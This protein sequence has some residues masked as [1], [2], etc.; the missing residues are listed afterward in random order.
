[1]KQKKILLTCFEPFD[2]RDRNA[3]QDVVMEMPAYI[4]EYRIYKLCLPTVFGRAADLAIEEAG[5]IH[6]GAVISVGEAAGRS[7]VT[8]ELVAINLQYARIPDN[9]GQAPMDVPI[10]ENGENALFSSLPVRRMAQAICEAGLP[11]E[12]S[13]SAGAY[14]CN[15]LMYRMLYYYQGSN[16]PCG[17][18]HVPTADTLEGDELIRALTAAINALE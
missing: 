3:S 9:I 14:V 16:I 10:V 8:P 5:R 4:G 17:F 11:G 15:D 2:G 18:I 12:V 1:M 13:Y 7:A 6:P